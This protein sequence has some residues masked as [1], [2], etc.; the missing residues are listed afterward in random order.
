MNTRLTAQDATTSLAAHVADKGRQIWQ[1]YGPSLGWKEL[2]AILQDSAF[3]RYP[4]E[5]R[6]DAGELELGEMAHP[7]CRGGR[8]EDGFI[9][10]VHPVFMTQLERVP[11]LVLY[12][13]VL[14]NYGDFV[15]AEDAEVFGAA[16]LGISREDYYQTLCELS[17]QLDGMGG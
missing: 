4:C 17:D 1:R 2:Q 9:M 11:H 15:S 14:V 7:V 13:L 12:Q 3:V 6:F 5:I 16:A 10:Y 8:P